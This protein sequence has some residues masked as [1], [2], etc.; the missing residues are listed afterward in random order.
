MSHEKKNM[1]YIN[2][3]LTKLINHATPGFPL[4][5]LGATPL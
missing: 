5:D 3:L 4:L 1:Q 2:I